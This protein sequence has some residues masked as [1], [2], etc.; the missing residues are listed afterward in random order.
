[1]VCAPCHRALSG[2]G[3][4]LSVGATGEFR[5]VSAELIDGEV[6]GEH[7]VAVAT[8]AWCR[9]SEPEVRKLLGRNGVALCDQCVA[10][11]CDILDAELG[12]WR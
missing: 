7:P 11:C 8:C 4:G 1:M 6:S 10:L 5:A 12:P 9:K 3:G 2:G